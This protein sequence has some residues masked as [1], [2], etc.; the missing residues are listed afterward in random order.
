MAWQQY[1][2]WRHQRKAWQHQHQNNGHLV[3]SRYVYQYRAHG[4]NRAPR[5]RV[6]LSEKRR[7]Q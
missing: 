4:V 2:A 1:L 3:L 6:K 5:Q 7:N